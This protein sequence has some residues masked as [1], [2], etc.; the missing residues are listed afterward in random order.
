[1]KKTNLNSIFYL[2]IMHEE[3]FLYKSFTIGIN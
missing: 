3:R 1:M 2:S